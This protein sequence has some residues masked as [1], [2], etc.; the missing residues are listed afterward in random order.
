MWQFRA[1]TARQSRQIAGHE[2]GDLCKLDIGGR[3]LSQSFW[4]VRVMALFGKYRG[5]ALAPDLFHRGK[6]AKLVVDKDVVLRGIETFDVA[7]LLLL[8]I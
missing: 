6:N 8:W 5:H 7:E 3:K 1:S 4:V 2:I